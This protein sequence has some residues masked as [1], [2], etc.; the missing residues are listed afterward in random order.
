LFVGRKGAFARRADDGNL[1]IP[2][3]VGFR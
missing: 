3:L 2:G 1:G